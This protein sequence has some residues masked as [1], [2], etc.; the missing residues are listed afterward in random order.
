[1][2]TILVVEDEAL[3][4]LDLA[5]SIEAM[6]YRVLGPAA[7]GEEAQR[8]AAKGNPDLVLMDIR[9]QGEADGIETARAITNKLPAK[10]MFM[11]AH[12][13]V[14]TRKRAM[15]LNPIGFLQKPWTA[16]QMQQALASA[17]A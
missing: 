3:I 9:I 10:L 1:M 4:A 15:S 8:L 12:T 17:F 5:C 6:G 11:T 16:R 2:R 14:N 13:D 7:D